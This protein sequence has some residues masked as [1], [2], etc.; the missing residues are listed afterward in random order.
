MSFYGFY[1]A[2]IFV[3]VHF[4][5][6]DKPGNEARHVRTYMITNHVKDS[7]VNWSSYQTCYM[8]VPMIAECDTECLLMHRGGD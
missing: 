2:C 8:L 3:Q 6:G 4:C 5:K 1:V 7:G